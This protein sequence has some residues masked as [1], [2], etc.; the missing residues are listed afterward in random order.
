[1]AEKGMEMNKARVRF[2][3]DG[4]WFA[5]LYCPYGTLPGENIWTGP[6]RSCEEAHNGAMNIR[7]GNWRTNVERA[8]RTGEPFIAMA[9]FPD[10]RAGFPQMV[11][12]TDGAFRV[13]G[14]RLTE[15]LVIWAW[16][17]RDVLGPWPMEDLA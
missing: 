9:R 5:T 13:P 15:E 4:W 6:Y 16:M 11:A 3:S 1:M 12:W 14:R 10:A 2:D 17:P 8:P 7:L